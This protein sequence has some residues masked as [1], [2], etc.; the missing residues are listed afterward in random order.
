MSLSSR[1]WWTCYAY[2]R[3]ALIRVVEWERERE[4]GTSAM[5]QQQQPQ[6]VPAVSVVDH[7]TLKSEVRFSMVRY[8]QGSKSG[9]QTWKLADFFPRCCVCGFA[10]SPYPLWCLARLLV[11]A[12]FL[13]PYVLLATHSLTHTHTLGLGTER[14]ISLCLKSS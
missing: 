10:C 1:C 7:D 5:T 3:R 13:L 4:T 12:A 8:E 9:A 11:P 14:C 6:L 2:R